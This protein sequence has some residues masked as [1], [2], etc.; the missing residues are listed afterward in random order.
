MGAATG[1]V[2]SVQ[3]LRARLPAEGTAGTGGTY[4]VGRTP[5][6]AG[7]VSAIRYIPDTAVTGAATNNKKL[8][9][10]NRGADG[11]G[12]TEIGSITF[13]SGTNAPQLD[14]TTVPLSGTAANL[15]VAAGVMIA[16]VTTVN[17]TGI[18]LP[19][20][21]IEVDIARD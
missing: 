5:A 6:A 10:Q 21:L 1:Q 11:T 14:D 16:V 19:A 9:V 8:A 12:T 4:A 20:G 7:A 13:A 15:D 18:V 17:G 2:A 3:T